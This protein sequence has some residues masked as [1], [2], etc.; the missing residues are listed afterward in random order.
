M[1]CANGREVPAANVNLL[2]GRAGGMMVA[3]NRMEIAQGVHAIRSP[4]YTCMGL[5]APNVYL[6]SGEEAALIDSGYADG[7]LART[8]IEYIERLGSA[9]LRYIVITHPHPDHIGGCRGIREATDAQV[10]LHSQAVER[11]GMYHLEADR[12]VDG[13]DMLDL[14]GLTLEMVHTPGH[15]R[16][17]ICVYVRE[18]RVLFTGDHVLGIGTTVIEA[19]D[20]NMAHYIESLRKL[21]EYDVDMVCPGHG[22]VIREPQLKINELIAHRQER[23]QQVVRCL[24]SGERTVRQ[25]V[26]EIYPELDPGLLFMAEM[27][28]VAHLSKLLDE[29][30]VLS[31]DDSYSLLET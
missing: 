2:C 3:G 9:D 11:A 5:F 19:P 27:Q 4:E 23:E 14:G 6:V 1:S 28:I 30:R 7:G 25:V 12:L 15:T 22:P 18:R 8:S 20:G 26:D 17:N 29:G 21:L 16:G 24:R 10:I 13:G 31:A